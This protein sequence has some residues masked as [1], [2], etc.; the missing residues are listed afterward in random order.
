MTPT[1]QQRPS[2]RSHSMSNAI[3]H[4]NKKNVEKLFET[5]NNG[6]VAALDRLVSPEYVGPQGDKGPA[7]FRGV[8]VGLRAAFPDLKYTI[9]ELV[10][11][12]DRV[13]VR[14]HWTGTHR[15]AFRAFPP[16]GK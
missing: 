8:V 11:E 13:A 15:G 1:S 9:D 5:F 2:T 3:Q 7:G 16:T 12:G 6:D 4:E 10:A 14:W